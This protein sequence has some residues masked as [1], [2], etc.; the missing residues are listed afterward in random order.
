MLNL[1][2]LIIFS[3]FLVT[4]KNQSMLLK[5]SS[6]LC[7]R[8]QSKVK[9]F[10]LFYHIIHTMNSKRGRKYVNRKLLQSLI[11][12]ENLQQSM[13]EI[14][15]KIEKAKNVNIE[16]LCSM[17]RKCILYFYRGTSLDLILTSRRISSVARAEHLRKKRRLNMKVFTDFD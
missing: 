4:K 2:C 12:P 11:L 1:I 3:R 9:K 8:V 16:D 14:N 7:I 10:H 6:I 13:P 15:D 17:L 5:Q